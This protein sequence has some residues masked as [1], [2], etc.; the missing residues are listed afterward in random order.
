MERSKHVQTG[1]WVQ[2]DYSLCNEEG[3]C[4]EASEVD[5]PLIYLHGFCQVI[6]GLEKG[7]GGMSIGQ[8]KR[9]AIPAQEAFGEYDA[10]GSF[11][12]GQEEFPDPASVQ[13]DDEFEM[14]GAEGITFVMRIIE[15]LEDG[16]V[17]DTNHPLAGISLHANVKVLDLWPATSEEIRIAENARSSFA[18]GQQPPSDFFSVPRD[19]NAPTGLLSPAQLV[20]KP[21]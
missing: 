6:D 18:T 5:E 16:F 10:D 21:S 8:T 19:S 2:L 3:E 15:R 4:I 17:V 1:M 20:R 11:I 13:V 12:L 14:E 9:W 7:I